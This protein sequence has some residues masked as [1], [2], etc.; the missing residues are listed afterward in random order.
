MRLVEVY[1][2]VV[3]SFDPIEME[4]VLQKWDEKLK[5]LNLKPVSELGEGTQGVAYALEDPNKVLKVTEDSREAN[6]AQKIVGKKYKHIY[7]VY[8]VFQFDSSGFFGIVQERLKRVEGDTEISAINAV[9]GL[10][11]DFHKSGAKDEEL[12]QEIDHIIQK[13]I[14]DPKGQKIAKDLANGMIELKKIGIEYSD[15]WLPNIMQRNNGDYVI[16]DLGYSRSAPER[17]EEI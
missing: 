9:K 7:E 6:A 2:S 15:L 13:E 5:S 12:L 8:R 16:I 3:E 14:S 1:K 4:K 11:N 17:I 10:L